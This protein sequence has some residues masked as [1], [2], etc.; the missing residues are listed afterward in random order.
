MGDREGTKRAM[1]EQEAREATRLRDA[2]YAALMRGAM[3]TAREAIEAFMPFD[4]EEALGMM[5]SLGIETNDAETAE[6][7]LKE[8]KELAPEKPYTRYLSARVAYMKGARAS[9]IEPLE[10][11]LED[12]KASAQIRERACNLL[13]RSCRQ[14]GEPEKAAK[15]DLEASRIAPQLGAGEYSNY[16]YDLH[17]LPGL[18]PE[19]QRAAAAR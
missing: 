9:L 1:N 12:K 18:S 7:A 16:L 10:S 5:T 2:A 14:L 4:R 11:L 3:K 17:Y 19:E 6:K 15:Y 8:L 13:G